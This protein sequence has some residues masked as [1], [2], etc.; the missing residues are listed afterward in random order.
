MR[1][2]ITGVTGQDGSY[3]A[4]LLHSQVHEVY[5]LLRGQDHPRADWITKLVPGITLLS[6]DLLDES[7]LRAAVG[8]CNPDWVFNLA[9]VS[10]PTLAW[11]QPVLTGEVTGLGALRLFEAV[12]RVAPLAHVVQASS[13]AQHGPYGAAKLFAHAVAVDYRERGL[14]ISCAVFGGHHS[15]RRGKSFFTR[16]VT[17]GVAAIVRGEADHLELGWLDRK[18]D[19]G[20]A[21]D[22]VAQLPGIAE[23]L[24]PSD[25]VMST[26]DPHSSREWVEQAF[27]CVDLDWEKYVRTNT[28]LGNVTDVATM[29]ADPDPRLE[30]EPDCDFAGLVRWMVESETA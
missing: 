3:L 11:K 13:I 16:K 21:Q 18:Q 19:W 26:G 27:A 24:P 10:S 23:S 15:P 29:T 6:G 9:A 2:L 7:S 22:F 5:G 12:H 17:A 4:Q 8:A 30:W 1:S 25:Y 14:H 20:N 28:A